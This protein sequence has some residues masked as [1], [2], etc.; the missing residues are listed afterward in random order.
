MLYSTRAV[1]G[2]RVS[3]VRAEFLSLPRVV[4]ATAVVAAR[5]PGSAAHAG[6]PRSKAPSDAG[7]RRDN[8]ARAPPTAS[9][10]RTGPPGRKRRWADAA[11]RPSHQ[12]PLHVSK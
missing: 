2:W 9:L 4:V 5:T 6:Q 7:H 3:D 1:G 8:P 11:H 12:R 10:S